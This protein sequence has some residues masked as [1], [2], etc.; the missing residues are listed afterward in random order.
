MS[1][2]KLNKLTPHNFIFIWN[3]A[4]KYRNQKAII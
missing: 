2:K 4:L 1:I 3:A